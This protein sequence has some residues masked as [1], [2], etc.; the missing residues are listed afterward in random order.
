MEAFIRSFSLPRSS[1]LVQFIEEQGKN[2]VGVSELVQKALT[3]LM[4]Q[5]ETDRLARVEAKVDKVL[6]YVQNKAGG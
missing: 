6:L 4:E 2:E 5:G 3:L 1:P